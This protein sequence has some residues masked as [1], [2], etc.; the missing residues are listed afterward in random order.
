MKLY[1]LLLIF[2]LSISI[3]AQCPSGNI[4]ISSQAEFDKFARNYSNCK[5]IDGNFT[6]TGTVTS[7]APLQNIEEIKGNLTIRNTNIVD[8]TINLAISKIDGNLRIL[9]NSSLKDLNSFNELVEVNDIYIEDIKG[10]LKGFDKLEKVNTID[11]KRLGMPSGRN[12]G[13][14]NIE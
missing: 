1:T 8:F 4:T 7:L 2:F 13:G 11:L 3:Y 5:T 14:R 12:F 6:I 9:E 10:Y